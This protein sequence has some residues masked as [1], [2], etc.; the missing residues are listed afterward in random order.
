M[1]THEKKKTVQC[2]RSKIIVITH[3]VKKSHRQSNYLDKI[4]QSSWITSHT[5]R[6]LGKYITIFSWTRRHGS[7]L[8]E[9]KC[10]KRLRHALITLE[11]LQN[12]HRQLLCL[13]ADD[14]GFVATA[15]FAYL[16]RLSARIVMVISNNWP[17]RRGRGDGFHEKKHKLQPCESGRIRRLLWLLSTSRNLPIVEEIWPL[18]TNLWTST[19]V[20][21]SN[22]LQN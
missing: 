7:I 11:A 13:L 20:K 8:R 14:V 18:M 15:L 9:K 17:I 6:F 3:R 2:S 5:F 22:V 4:S 21:P 12:Q 10:K 19:E 1:I 16:W